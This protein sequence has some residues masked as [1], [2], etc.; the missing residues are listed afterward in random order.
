MASILQGLRTAILN[1]TFA[2]FILESEVSKDLRDFLA[3]TVSP[4][5]YFYQT[6][7]RVAE[8]GNGEVFQDVESTM[9]TFNH[10]MCPRYLL[11]WC[12]SFEQYGLR[13]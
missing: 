4:D 11:Y 12:T 10:G 1:R 7:I 6:F 8:G 5:E 13:L 3:D 2:K 9:E